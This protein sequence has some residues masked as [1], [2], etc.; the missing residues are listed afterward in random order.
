M[1]D[2]VTGIAAMIIFAAIVVAVIHGINEWMAGWQP[3]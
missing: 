2:I 3:L 1:N